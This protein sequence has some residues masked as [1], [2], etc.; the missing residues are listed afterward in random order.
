MPFWL[1]V[2]CVKQ[3][4]VLA[5]VLLLFGVG[6]AASQTYLAQDAGANP[7]TAFLSPEQYTNAFFGF[8]LRLPKDPP[9]QE[10]SVRFKTGPSR[11]LLDLQT[12][13]ASFNYKPRLT[14]LVAWADQSSDLSAEAVRKVAGSPKNA[15]TK[16]V[17]IAGKEF[18]RAAWEEKNP[19]GKSYTVKFATAAN[20]YILAFMVTSF[21]G[22]LASRMEHYIEQIKFFDSVKA[23]EIA[24][25]TAKPYQ[26]RFSSESPE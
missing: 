1:I 6:V 14:L 12:L 15:D 17:E 20:G 7:E 10:S 26:P 16:R 4:R 23:R 24:G 18:W 8:S 5:T 2:L 11:L 9:F 21:D 3:S 19:E 22:R 25:P 13:T